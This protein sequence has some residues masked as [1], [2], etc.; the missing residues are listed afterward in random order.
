M[1]TRKGLVV[2]TALVLAGG[3]AA[4]GDA[5]PLVPDTTA[6]STETVAQSASA[7]RIAR[8]SNSTMVPIHG[9]AML[10][11]DPT[12]GLLECV[13]EGTS[14]VVAEFPARFLSEGTFSHLGHTTSVIEVL[15]CTASTDGSIFGPGEAVHTAA[16]GDELHAEWTG[17]FQADGSSELWITFAGGTGRFAGASGEGAGGG[18]SDPATLAGAWWFEGMLSRVGAK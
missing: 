12:G 6:I 14:D 10:G 9:K 3:L 8:T 11:V 4:C 18:L 5:D 7:A 13:L 17:R 1:L 2:C 15:S 16:N